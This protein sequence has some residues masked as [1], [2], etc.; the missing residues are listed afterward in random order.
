MGFVCEKQG[1]AVGVVVVVAAVAR[2]CCCGGPPRPRSP[3][4]PPRSSR[5][6]GDPDPVDIV[7]SVDIV[8]IPSYLHSPYRGQRGEQRPVDVPGHEVDHQPVG[9]AEGGQ[10]P[11]QVRPGPLLPRYSR[12]YGYYIIDI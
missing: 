11:R 7:D 12:Y 6:P 5:T 4:P 3:P 9:E 8:D 1:E 2:R 10:H